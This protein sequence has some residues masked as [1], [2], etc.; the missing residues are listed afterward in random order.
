MAQAATGA[1]IVLGAI[2]QIV[3]KATVS[4]SDVPEGDVMRLLS[5]ASMPLGT[6]PRLLHAAAEE[7]QGM[8]SST[9]LD[10]LAGTILYSLGATA[11]GLADLLMKLALANP[12][13]VHW[14]PPERAER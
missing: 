12:H 2:Y 1:G 6:L 9:G 3:S 11:N 8:R 13:H 4:L 5:T 7:A 14:Q 10:N